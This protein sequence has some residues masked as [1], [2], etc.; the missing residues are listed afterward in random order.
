MGHIPV[1]LVLR[2]RHEF[3]DSLGY[4]L[5]L[6]TKEGTAEGYKVTEPFPTWGQ[7]KEEQEPTEELS[8]WKFCL[9]ERAIVQ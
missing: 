3:K 6:E 9:G 4:V 5:R 1:I 8:Y 2:L 7:T